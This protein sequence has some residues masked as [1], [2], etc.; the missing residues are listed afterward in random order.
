V[1]DERGQPETGVWA[2]A[3]DSYP[4]QPGEYRPRRAKPGPP[5][6]YL[7]RSE[8]PLRSGPYLRSGGGPASEPFDTPPPDPLRDPIPPPGRAQSG[9]HGD[10]PAP[11]SAFGW[12][13][14]NGNFVTDRRA[15]GAEPPAAPPRPA[16]A[17]PARERQARPQAAGNQPA[18]NQVPRNQPAQDQPGRDQP[19]QNR[20]AQNRPAQ[21]R[22]AEW[23]SGKQDIRDEPVPDRP[24]GARGGPADSYRT[25][26][27]RY[28]ADFPTQVFMSSALAAWDQPA[29]AA[30]A[31]NWPRIAEP[32]PPPGRPRPAE[33]PGRY[34]S[35]WPPGRP[36][37]STPP[38]PGQAPAQS[39]PAGPRHATGAAQ[40]ATAEPG[41]AH[42]RWERDPVA[43]AG[44]YP[45]ASAQRAR[46]RHH[47]APFP[48]AQNPAVLY[49]APPTDG[50]PAGP[51]PARSRP[52]A[53]RRG[54]PGGVLI[55][56]ACLAVLVTIA[57]ILFV[58]LP[59]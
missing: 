48:P 1:G 2:R 19:A 44:P 58:A 56:A 27:D 18:Q 41:G 26:T 11:G 52:P 5:D 13:N 35:A 6:P 16:R 28:P 4:A 8:D 46:P 32:T 57:L 37:P 51:P 3:A 29:Q 40:S 42:P 59:G 10:A 39:R 50:R 22:P 7:P 55:G 30:P 47:A 21:N 9:A 38:G 15:P 54:L 43:G 33:P 49:P 53:E 12:W 20:P 24:T 36:Q 17:E 34:D 25:D 31:G 23:H 45:P 14:S